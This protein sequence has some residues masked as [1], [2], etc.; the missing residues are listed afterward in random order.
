V[1]A[2]ESRVVWFGG[3]QSLK[4]ARSKAGECWPCC[5]FSL[6]REGSEQLHNAFVAS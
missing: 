2:F 6:G 4:V 1:R 5:D 3:K